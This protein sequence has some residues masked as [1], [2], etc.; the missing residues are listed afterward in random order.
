MACE[1]YGGD[2]AKVIDQFGVDSF[3]KGWYSETGTISGDIVTSVLIDKILHHE[4]SKYQDILIFNCNVFGRILCLDDVIQ[5]SEKDEFVYQEMVSFL[6]L[7]S[8]PKPQKVLIVGGGDGGVVR[9][10]TKHPLVESITL[11]EIDERVIELSKKYLPF[12]ATGFESPKL[13]VHVGDGAEYMK[14]HQGEFDVIITDSPDPKGAAICLFQKPYYESLKQALKPGGVIAS[15]G[16]GFWFDLDIIRELVG[17]AKSVFPVVDY[18][19]SYVG[20]FP[21]GHLGYV[22]CSTSPNTNFRNPV[23]KF[24][25]KMLKELGL[26]YYTPDVHRAAFALALFSGRGIRTE[27]GALAMMTTLLWMCSGSIYP[28][29]EIKNAFSTLQK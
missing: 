16:E 22:V 25:T 11:C 17:V 15:Q 4:K 18:A 27:W 13:T 2:M 6:P 29:F 7:N 1:R 3:K 9:E 24:S 19:T 10:V 21:G 26:R 20:S 12:M 28:V 23:H 8:H 5:L 14:A